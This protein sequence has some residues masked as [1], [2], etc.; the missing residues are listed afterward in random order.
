MFAQNEK[1]FKELELRVQ[2]LKEKHM[3][4]W[5]WLQN[6]QMIRKV[7][8]VV[9]D[10]LFMID[11]LVASSSMAWKLTLFPEV[12]TPWTAKAQWLMDY[13]WRVSE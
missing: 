1:L 12:K 2:R 4:G 8:K 10:R 3:R 7:E 9:V 5:L 6:T 11:D 13:C